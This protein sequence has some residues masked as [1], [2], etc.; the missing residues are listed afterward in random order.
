V[1]SPSVVCVSEGVSTSLYRSVGVTSG[2]RF[3]KP[4]STPPH[5]PPSIDGCQHEQVGP[6]WWPRGHGHNLGARTRASVPWPHL[7]PTASL[8]GL[9]HSAK[10]VLAWFCVGLACCSSLAFLCLPRKRIFYVYHLYFICIP[11]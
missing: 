5:C 4:G 6:R 11:A 8:L 10:V 3:T 1:R 9:D 7:R 2:A